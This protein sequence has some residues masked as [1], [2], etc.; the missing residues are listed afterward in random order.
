MS[1]SY[2]VDERVIKTIIN[3]NVQCRSDDDKIKFIVYYKNIK[4]SNLIIR[5]NLSVKNKLKCS[6]VVYQFNCPH[7]DCPLWPHASYI[8][9]T[10]TTLSRRLTMHLQKGAIRDHYMNHHDS[11]ISRASIV[12]NTAILK[13]INEFHRLATFEALLI[14]ITT[15]LINRQDTGFTRTLK[16]FTW[17]INT[18][19][20]PLYFSAAS[21]K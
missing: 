15:P 3:R 1:S 17:H 18:L 19:V 11:R 9:Y 16:L 13:K 6:N 20:R 14:K 2:K 10:Q 5:N 7:E 21:I 12:E 8:G 4:T